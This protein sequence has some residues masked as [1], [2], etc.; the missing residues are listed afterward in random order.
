MASTARKQ[1]PIEEEPLKGPA[2][3]DNVEIKVNK[4]TG[5][6]GADVA[7]FKGNKIELDFEA[8]PAG[9]DNV[10]L[11]EKPSRTK[12]P[13]TVTEPDEKFEPKK[14]DELDNDQLSPETSNNLENSKTP[15]KLEN[16]QDEN[17]QNNF[18][19]EQD[20]SQTEKPNLQP[21]NIDAEKPKNTNQQTPPIKEDVPEQDNQKQQEQ[22]LK[23]PNLT[24]TTPNSP[25]ENQSLDDK[26]NVV[27]PV[28]DG[29]PPVPN[30]V[31]PAPT[32]NQPATEQP[33]TP[34]NTTTPPTVNNEA[35]QQTGP[36]VS[37]N[38]TPNT[39]PP[40]DQKGVANTMN[41]PRGVND[42][43][44]A[45]LGSQMGQGV[46]NK[47]KNVATDAKGTV[48][49]KVASIANNLQSDR[50]RQKKLKK[51]RKKLGTELASL[52]KTVDGMKTNSA[53][54]LLKTFAPSI[55]A[56][57]TSLTFG[58][59][60]AKD[61]VKIKILQTNLVTLKSIKELL[62][63]MV[64]ILD[65]SE[66]LFNISK[67]GLATTEIVIGFFIIAISPI[68]AIPFFIFKF[69]T[70]TGRLS[71][72]VTLILKETIDPMIEKIQKQIEPLKKKIVLRKKIENINDLLAG[73][74]NDRKQD[75]VQKDQQETNQSTPEASE[76]KKP[77]TTNEP[78]T[79]NKPT[80]TN[81]QPK[82]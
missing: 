33:A 65:Y 1:Q 32:E 18:Q 79:T 10:E 20:L 17:Q 4:V 31:P 57:L 81:E 49:N 36:H 72:A 54:L 37:S 24:P 61:S 67:I 71:K 50:S 63:A 40:E 77:T 73:T 6:K 69:C 47:I 66:S 78:A 44:A 70:S 45:G 15:P 19:P 22:E 42:L 13:S 46:A 53:M 39:I 62:H 34:Q 41:Q 56:R 48:K 68:L 75:R 14:P 51:E 82:K 26:N 21:P 60:N 29:Q 12:T 23:Q 8:T 59:A 11:N 80:T 58:K 52:E 64:A 16:G 35:L 5:S 38:H 27:P 2:A 7:S 76:T 25:T 30:S 74:K 9:N 3:N 28:T 55:Y 43:G